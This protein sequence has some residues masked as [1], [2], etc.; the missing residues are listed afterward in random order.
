MSGENGRKVPGWVKVALEWGP[1]LAY[2]VAY[3]RL[4]DQHLTVW[5]TDYNGFIIVTACFIPV[6]LICTGLTWAITGKLSKM[7]LVTAVLVT[8]FGSLSVAFNDERFFKMKPTLIYLIFGGALGF[9]LLRGKSYLRLVL[10]E[11]IPLDH[12]G[13]MILTRRLCALFFALA[14]ANEVIWRLTSTDTW[15]SFKTFGLPIVTF[16]FFAAQ[17][18]LFKRHGIE[19]PAATDPGAGK[20]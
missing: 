11:A 9:G 14:V 1:I 6:I 4:K 19:K 3:S 16:V 13:W 5:G 17:S 15:V 8:V 20:S 2:F 18:S 12:A 7:Q 10:D